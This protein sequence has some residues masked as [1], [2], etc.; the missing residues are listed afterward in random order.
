[1]R[2][3]V[4]CCEIAGCRR[5]TACFSALPW[6]LMALSGANDVRPHVSF[7]ERS[8]RGELMRTR[9][10]CAKRNEVVEY[11]NECNAAIKMHH[12]LTSS[13]KH[14]PRTSICELERYSTSSN[15]SSN[16]ST[17][18]NRQTNN[19]HAPLLAQPPLRSARLSGG[20][21]QCGGRRAAR[22]PLIVQAVN[23]LQARSLIRC[24]ATSTG[25]RALRS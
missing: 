21:E 12:P 11:N 23:K 19:N 3:Y 4:N 13:R 15:A 6:Q 2:L 17:Q 20:I 25:C 14:R 1:M 22:Y 5:Q 8:R 18:A 9:P 24:A 7:R 10:N 16:T